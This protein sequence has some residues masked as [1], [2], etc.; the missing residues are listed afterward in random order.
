MDLVKVALTGEV[1]F[2]KNKKGIASGF[3]LLTNEQ[4]E[5][6]KLPTNSKGK[7]VAKEVKQ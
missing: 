2:I 5:F 3:I 1:Q 4:M 6:K 7:E